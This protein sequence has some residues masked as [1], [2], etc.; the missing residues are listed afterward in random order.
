MSVTFTTSES[1]SLKIKAKM[2]TE[3]TFDCM[4]LREE[5]ELLLSE[6]SNVIELNNGCCTLIVGDSGSGKT[7]LVK[8]FK[9]RFNEQYAN[10]VSPKDSEQACY[11][12]SPSNMSPLDLY[13]AILKGFNEPGIIEGTEVQLRTRIAKQMQ[14]KRYRVLIFDEFQQVVEKVGI[15][16]V[17]QIA[18]YLKELVDEFNVY[19][20]F[21]G[22]SKVQNLLSINEQFASRNSLTIKK[23]LLSVSTQDNYKT[24][25]SYLI[26]LNKDLKFTHIDFTDPQINLPLFATTNGDLRQ[27]TQTLSKAILYAAKRQRDEMLLNDLIQTFSPKLI[28]GR[29]QVNPYRQKFTILKKELGVHYEV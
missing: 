20:V 6:A 3:L 8:K 28:K 18:D 29:T 22:T 14:T 7:T 13:R 12:R 2:L 10:T 23:S 15:K 4:A 1:N 24:Y 25:V 19:L 11:I 17:R 5:L 26:T 21:A 27:L 16:S 9:T